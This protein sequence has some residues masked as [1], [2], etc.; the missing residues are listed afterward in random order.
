MHYTKI[1]KYKKIPNTSG[2]IK[3]FMK[4]RFTGDGDCKSH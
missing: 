3:I 1:Q 4:I 2:F